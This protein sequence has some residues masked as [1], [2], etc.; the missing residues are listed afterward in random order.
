[1]IEITIRT[2]EKSIC[3]GFTINGHAEYNEYGKDIVCAAVSVLVI[4]TINSI[5]HFTEDRFLANQVEEDGRIEF[6]MISEI[7]KESH[8][9]I[10]SLLLGLHGIQDEYGNQ[11]IKFR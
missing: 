2:N 7:S 10:D 8:L 9:L 1:M 6:D 4:N 3:N 5:E 11:Y